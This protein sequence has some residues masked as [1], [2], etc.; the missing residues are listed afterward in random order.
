MIFNRT[1]FSEMKLL[2]SISINIAMMS[3]TISRSNYNM[4]QLLEI[5]DNFVPL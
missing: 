1:I 3:F 5:P 4:I 2:F